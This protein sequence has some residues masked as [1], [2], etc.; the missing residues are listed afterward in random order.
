LMPPNPDMA[1]NFSISTWF[2]F[3]VIVRWAYEFV[4]GGGPLALT[5]CSACSYG[6]APSRGLRA[7]PEWPWAPSLYDEEL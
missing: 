5:S 6:E 4:Q 2:G 1:A 3:S 7:N